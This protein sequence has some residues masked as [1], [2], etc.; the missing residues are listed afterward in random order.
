MTSLP[1][2]KDLIIADLGARNAAL[3]MLVTN[4]V[5]SLQHLTRLEK[6]SA[7]E[8]RR[9]AGLIADDMTKAFARVQIEAADRAKRNSEP[10][11]VLPF[12]APAGDEQVPA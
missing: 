4:T 12:G 7:N 3:E 1:L 9:Q 6:I 10:A 5:G 8:V 2:N 11:Q